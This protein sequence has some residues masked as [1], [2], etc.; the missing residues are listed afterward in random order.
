[1]Q[2]FLKGGQSSE[3]ERFSG[4]LLSV[5]I[6]HAIHASRQKHNT[7]CA[8]AYAFLTP[9]RRPLVYQAAQSS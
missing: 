4:S 7:L 1:M 9:H 8:G 5:Y 3:K 2:V 6:Q